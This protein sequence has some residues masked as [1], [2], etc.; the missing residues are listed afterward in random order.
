MKTSPRRLFADATGCGKV[1]LPGH[2]LGNRTGPCARSASSRSPWTGCTRL[3]VLGH[4]SSMR[5]RLSRSWDWLH[6]RRPGSL[7][8]DRDSGGGPISPGTKF[9]P[10]DPAPRRHGATSSSEDWK[11]LGY[12]V[13]RPTG[14]HLR[15]STT[16]GGEHIC[17]PAPHPQD[18]QI[19]DARLQRWPRSRRTSKL[20]VRPA[21]RES[22]F[23]GATSLRTWKRRL[24]GSTGRGRRGFNGATSLRTWKHGCGRRIVASAGRASMGP[25]L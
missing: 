7:R 6:E 13:S 16:S 11:R 25:R 12:T 2:V 10:Y 1:Q 8:W 15:L 22:G 21:P 17:D 3:R 19:C 14:S 18:R 9:S 20:R 24:T 4:P 5:P 23:N